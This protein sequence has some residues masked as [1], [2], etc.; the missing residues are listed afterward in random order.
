[1]RAS[2]HVE[3]AARGCT[4]T[5]TRARAWLPVTPATRRRMT[6]STVN[7]LAHA[8]AT[9]SA[10]SRLRAAVTPSPSKV[11]ASPSGRSNASKKALDALSP[12]A[13]AG[14]STSRD[15]RTASSGTSVV[16]MSVPA[17]GL[18]VYAS[19]CVSPPSMASPTN[20]AQTAA[21]RSGEGSVAR[22]SARAAAHA[23]RSA[24]ASP[25]STARSILSTARSSSACFPCSR[26]HASKHPKGSVTPRS[27][28]NPE[29]GRAATRATSPS[30]AALYP[31]RSGVA[32]FKSRAR[33]AAQS[34][35]AARRNGPASIADA[36]V[37]DALES[38]SSALAI[39]RR[40]SS[41]SETRAACS[42]SA[43]SI[44]A[45]LAGPSAPK[46]PPSA[47]PAAGPVRSETHSPTSARAA[48]RTDADAVAGTPSCAA[49]IARRVS[50]RTGSAVTTP[51]TSRPAAA[52]SSA[53]E[54]RRANTTSGVPGGATPRAAKGSSRS[55]SAMI[56][57]ADPGERSSR[58]SRAS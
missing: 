23:A 46:E 21:A 37:R 5:A 50:R 3:P 20:D 39:D 16:D 6:D 15:A 7:A 41:T 56:P 32:S 28:W 9:A 14:S 42:T 40:A 58:W 57:T 4:T 12:P 45:A 1:M 53:P 11:D 17:L 43:S 54:T 8:S 24:A 49:R 10:T 13:H 25:A 38:C 33:G 31:A 18:S 36:S 26:T 2:K 44:S 51:R 29:A 55:T 19:A 35:A 47:P 27:A 52:T 48:C 22:A 30:E 34:R